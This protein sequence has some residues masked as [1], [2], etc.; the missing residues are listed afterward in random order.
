MLASTRY[1]LDISL[2]LLPLAPPP[3][4]PCGS[5]QPCHL[6]VLPVCNRDIDAELDRT[7]KVLTGKTQLPPNR[8]QIGEASKGIRTPLR[9]NYLRGRAHFT[10]I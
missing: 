9:W 8:W 6:F 1:D 7:S 4:F 5:D 10:G 3:S 2:S